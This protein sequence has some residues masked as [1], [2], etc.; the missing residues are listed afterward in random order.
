M[1]KLLIAL[2]A[3]GF[4][5]T[6]SANNL[7][8]QI[9][10]AAPGSGLAPAFGGTTGGVYI[11][12]EDM[13]GATDDSTSYNL[14]GEVYYMVTE[15]IQVGGMLGFGDRDITG[16]ELMYNLGVA[17]RY[18]LDTDFRDSMFFGVGLAYS[19]LGVEPV[20]STRISAFIQAGKR[21]ALSDHLT[22]TPNVTYALGVGGDEN[23][24]EGST[25]AINILSF[26]GFMNL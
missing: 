10:S 3:F 19:E 13:P 15:N 16:T 4:V 11:G 7:E 9:S 5:S 14:Q 1:K 12:D 22:Y 2:V 26:S 8:I 21:F 6:A 24:D 18:N 17:A 20:D 23:Y 25:I